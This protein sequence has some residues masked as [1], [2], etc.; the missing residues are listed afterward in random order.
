MEKYAKS[1]YN[2]VEARF[3]QTTCTILELF[4][5]FD[6]ELL[7]VSSSPFFCLYG[8]NENS[9]LAEQLFPEKSVKIIMIDWDQFKSELIDI[10]KKYQSY[11]K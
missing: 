4:G 1:M 3:P 9:F 2:I 6:V 10:K 5:I 11:L 8:K 7:P